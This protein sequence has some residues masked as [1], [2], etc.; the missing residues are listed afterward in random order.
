MPT[1]DEEL[2]RRA[3]SDPPAWIVTPTRRLAR[4]LTLR[5]AEL[6]AAAGRTVAQTPPIL[7]LDDWMQR[8]GRDLLA[9]EV[10]AGRGPGRVLLSPHAERVL[11]ERVILATPGDL[12]KELL[13]TSA[14]AATAADAWARLCHW[15]EPSWSGPMVEDVE[16]FRDWVPV[17]RE[18]LR[19]GGFV[20]A[21]E[22][23]RLVADAVARGALDE[24]LPREAV[25]PAFEKPD[26]RLVRF[27]EALR[28]RG[29][30]VTDSLGGDGRPAATPKVWT[31]AT[32]PV[33]VRAVAAR[34]RERLLA[35]PG[36]RIAVLAP[37]PSAYGKRLERIFEE[38]LDPAGILDVHASSTRRFDFA[39]APSLADYPLVS[40]ALDVLS[41]DGPNLAFETASALL[42]SE[43]PR[44]VD[45]DEAEQE[46]QR[47][48]RAQVEASLR[49]ERSAVLRLAGSRES[50]ATRLRASGMDSLASRF[51]KLAER[52]ARDAETRRAP[53]AWRREWHER[54]RVAGWPGALRGDVEGLV[55]RRWRDAID[56]F[57][58]LEAVEPTMDAHHALSRLRA[59]CADSRVQP[60][61]E[62]RSVQVLSLL[63]AAGLDFD[64]TFAIGLTSTAFPPAPRPNPL[65]PVAWQREQRGM[66]RT[67]VEGERELAAA[68]WERVRR[69]TG[70]L[71]A[72]WPASGESAEEQSPSAVLEVR[73][74]D[75]PPPVDAAPWWLASAQQGAALE[76]RPADEAG[77]PLVRRGGSQILQQQSDCPFRAFA[78]TRLGAER[79]D[80]IVPQPDAARRGTLVHEALAF[81]YARVQS[82][83]TLD[84]LSEENILDEARAAAA[85][86]LEK[87]ASFFDDAADLAD[88]M[89]FWL[90]EVV[91]GWMRYERG[92]RTTPWEIDSLEYDKTVSFPPGVEDPLVIRFRPDRI[93][94]VED[95]GLVILDFKTSTTPKTSS[96]WKGERPEEPQ[97]P[98]YL[99]L[100]EQEGARVDGIA[101]A[102]LSARDACVLEGT[103]AREFAEKF[104]PPGRAKSRSSADYDTR[105]EEWRGAVRAL[106]EGYLG[107]DVRVLPRKADVCKFCSSH[108]L[109]RVAE[110]GAPDEDDEGAEEGE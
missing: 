49:R 75:A 1:R 103:G 82:S 87:H 53:G 96:R 55:F 108:A 72:S 21:A 109:C 88:A 69:S 50:L 9:R 14:L 79:L 51:E 45:G 42:L 64:V 32:A 2:L 13:D 105:V 95:G 101:F 48:R 44:A 86:A 27:L 66:P 97:L 80:E 85:H 106:A 24:A 74:G 81:A 17:F 37:D 65:L 100:M 23:G 22:L 52:L 56:E 84:G 83:H 38:E 20:T 5:V 41:L 34:I 76:E 110:T 11:W 36:L 77:P 89:R 47:V 28:S 40:A 3:D 12:P 92:V 54:L 18:R 99:A 70:E 39:E 29:V 71:H 57:A 30:A 26:P 94:R 4:T 19:S 93:D 10:A 91:A 107:G 59:I 68:V 67:S 33:E 15:G 73:K 46:R 98:L 31:A 102:N 62:S 7:A 43:Y 35:E 25:A 60:A 90:V 16:R 104:R 8:L 6:R 63:D 78:A 61:S 58:A